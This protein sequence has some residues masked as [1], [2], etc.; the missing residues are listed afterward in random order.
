MLRDSQH[1]RRPA[2]VAG[3]GAR[4]RG[5]QAARTRA[6]AGARER[7]GPAPRESPARG[8]GEQR[9]SETKP[10]RGGAGLA[11]DAGVR[12]CSCARVAR[13]LSVPRREVDQ[14]DRLV[15]KPAITTR[16]AEIVP[17]RS[18]RARGVFARGCCA[19]AHASA[20]SMI[21]DRWL[22][23][24]SRALAGVAA[25][26]MH[27]AAAKS[28]GRDRQGVIVIF[29]QGNALRL[30]ATGIA[31]S[32]GSAPSTNVHSQISRRA[33]RASAAAG[34]V[35]HAGVVSPVKATSG[36][37]TTS[38]T[39][40]PPARSAA[41]S[42]P[43][44]RNARGWSVSQGRVER[45]QTARRGARRKPGEL[46]LQ[47]VAPAVHHVPLARHR[48]L[49]SSRRPRRRRVAGRRFVCNSRGRWR[50]ARVR[51][52]RNGRSTWRRS[53]SACSAPGAIGVTVSGM[54]EWSSARYAVR[55][56]ST[57]AADGGGTSAVGGGRL[58]IARVLAWK[59]CPDIVRIKRA[60]KW[61][62]SGSWPRAR[63]RAGLRC[64]RHATNVVHVAVRDAQRLLR[65]GGGRGRARV[66]PLTR[67]LRRACARQS[68]PAQAPA[69]LL[70]RL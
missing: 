53:R 62:V 28:G 41:S 30:R 56:A 35:S 38:A 14:Q 31:G 12:S 64:A 69:Q 21:S 4:A 7:S 5:R 2:L 45:A 44:R 26:G 34:S 55:S 11:A 58:S 16:S 42:A 18:R 60:D 17:R 47:L 59:P 33:A 23:P 66:R 9:L 27:S 29:Q 68:L 54:S 3:W 6:G 48:V 25:S 36:V 24:H 46:R 65:Q 63:A 32:R 57:A 49:L 70:S 13:P 40:V 50:T 52:V 19:G 8:R 22:W 1:R 37:S 61:S 39:S 15:L 51:T 43:C 67:V 20:C 10:A